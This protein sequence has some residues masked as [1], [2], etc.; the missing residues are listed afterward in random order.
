LFGYAAKISLLTMMPRHI[1]DISASPAAISIDYFTAAASS[2]LDDDRFLRYA[3]IATDIAWPAAS[4][5]IFRQ[6]MIVHYFH[7][8]FFAIDA[9]IEPLIG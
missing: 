2:I 8:A 6:R 9:A 1:A 5:F 7:L 3:D 4:S